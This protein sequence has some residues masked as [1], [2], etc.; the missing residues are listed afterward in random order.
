MHMLIYIEHVYKG[1]LKCFITQRMI[2]DYINVFPEVSC[3]Y[4]GC[5]LVPIAIFNI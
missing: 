1:N 2:G 3:I 4:I 5:L